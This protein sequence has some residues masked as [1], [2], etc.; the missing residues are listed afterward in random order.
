MGVKM[1]S[2]RGVYFGCDFAEIL[3]SFCMI[4]YLT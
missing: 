2:D 3:G 1:H 4:L